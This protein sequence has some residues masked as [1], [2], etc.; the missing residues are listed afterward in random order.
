[1]L[2]ADEKS[3]R[4]IMRQALAQNGFCVYEA[5]NGKEALRLAEIHKDK[6]DLLLTDVVMPG[7]NG[8]DLVTAT[9][10]VIPGLPVL[11]MSGYQENALL[12]LGVD[13]SGMKLLKKPFCPQDLVAKIEAL[14]SA[15]P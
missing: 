1:L 11:Y 12:D 13:S 8:P 3:A 10:K 2:V 14:L 6:I 9:T 5:S 4:P 15:A 7:M